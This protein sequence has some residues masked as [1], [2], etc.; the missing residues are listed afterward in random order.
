MY[1]HEVIFGVDAGIIYC[2]AMGGFTNMK[3]EISTNDDENP[4]AALA[5]KLKPLAVQVGV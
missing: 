1:V 5:K 2:R 4:C 3:S